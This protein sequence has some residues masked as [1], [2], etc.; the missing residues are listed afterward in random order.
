MIPNQRKKIE[1]KP[2]IV[3]SFF[4]WLV[5]I[6]F[7]VWFA[8]IIGCDPGSHLGKF[9]GNAVKQYEKRQK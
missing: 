6:V 1:I 2:N 9:A 7:L 3:G 4:R 5:T 8:Q